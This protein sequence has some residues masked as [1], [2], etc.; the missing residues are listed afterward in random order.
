MGGYDPSVSF[1]QHQLRDLLDFKIE[2]YV[3]RKYLGAGVSADVFLAD[4]K[5]EHLDEGVPQSVAIK[6]YRAWVFDKFPEQLQR[7]DREVAV[8][9]SIRHKFL[10]RVFD[11]GVVRISNHLRAYVVMEAVQGLTLT[12]W[13]GNNW[14][15]SEKSAVGRIKEVCAAVHAL[16][17]RG[18]CHRDLKPDNVMIRANNTEA[19][20]MDFGVIK[21]AAERLTE[22]GEFL[23]TR[24]YAAPEYIR[25]AGQIDFEKVDIYGIGGIAYYLAEG[26]DLFAEAKGDSALLD[27]VANWAPIFRHLDENHPLRALIEQCLQKDPNKRPATIQQVI[28]RLQ[29]LA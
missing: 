11:R 2:G 18:I 23:G 29:S 16:H 4:A 25:S 10:V 8:M 24:R 26:T 28:S 12:Q 14:P 7:I 19:V 3:L 22:P 5:P 15:I 13:V 6:V 20:L 9:R 17:D 1:R 27:A 21:V